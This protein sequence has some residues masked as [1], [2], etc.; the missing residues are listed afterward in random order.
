MIDRATVLSQLPF[1]LDSIDL[2]QLGTK[3]SG[4][5]R[6]SFVKDNRRILVTTDR[7]SA[8]DRVLTTIPFKGQVVCQMATYWF[9][10]TK[11]LVPNHILSVPH[12]NVVVTKEVEI[13]P[14]EVVVRGYLTG[15]AWRDYQGGKDISGISLPKG[16]KRSARFE[17]PLITP[18]T[19]APRG[20]HDLPISSDEIV[21]SGLVQS[22]IWEQVCEYSLKLF[23]FGTKRAADQGLILVDTKY[24]FG[25]ITEPSGKKQLLLAD[26]IHTQDSSRYWILESYHDAYDNGNEPP[27]LDKEF[28]RRWLIEQGYMGEGT[29]PEFTADFRVDIAL[30]YIEAF[31]RITGSSFQPAVGKADDAIQKA[32]A[33]L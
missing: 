33:R 27:M 4:K 22:A 28:V 20:E 31:E 6:D 1:T 21:R 15:S 19:K 9:E 12:P 7:L 23:E 10:Q 14:V 16:L 25:L 11:N 29:A 30:K 8:F 5:V 3:I 18:S 13:L 17:H 2:P 26:E 32:L 24:E